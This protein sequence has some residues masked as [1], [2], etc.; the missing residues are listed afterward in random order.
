MGV[1][2]KQLV[3]N[4]TL[5][6][7]I[8]RVRG[9]A[10]ILD[11][12]LATLYGVTAK[13]LNEQV[14]RNADRFPEDFMFQLSE[15]E[16]KAL[17]SQIATSN[18]GRG[19]RRYAPYAFTEHG[20]VMAANVLNSKQAI[21][22]SVAIVRA[23]VRLRRMAL[24]VGA[25]ARKVAELETRYDASFSAVFDAIRQLMLPPDAPRKPIGFGQK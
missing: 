22:M 14:R 18:K 10:V 5:Q 23:F 25:L 13:R 7:I 9:Q 3:T 8:I 11:A 4:P 20:A 6:E 16:W 19:G 12:D 2:M 1:I 24:S 17:R 15:T 21:Q